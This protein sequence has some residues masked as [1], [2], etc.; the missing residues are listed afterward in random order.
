MAATRRLAAILAA[1]IARYSRLMGADEEGTLERLK[2]RRGELVDSKIA[3]H[4]GRIVKTTGDGVLGDLH[5][6]KRPNKFNRAVAR[7]NKSVTEHLAKS[8][9]L[10]SKK[11]NGHLARPKLRFAQPQ[12]SVSRANLQWTAAPVNSHLWK[13]VQNNSARLPLRMMNSRINK[14]RLSIVAYPRHNLAI[15]RTNYLKR[16]TS[17]LGEKL[18][19]YSSVEFIEDWPIG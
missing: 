12:V 8:K 19:K 5:R 13:M 1:D 15:C 10:D 2:A 6:A 17:E 7:V 16:Y 4:R 18:N 14:P 9:R 11:E 3:E